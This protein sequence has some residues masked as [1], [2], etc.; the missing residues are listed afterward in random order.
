MNLYPKYA[1]LLLSVLFLMSII[2]CKKSATEPEDKKGGLPEG[3]ETLSIDING[4]SRD[5][6]LHT[7]TNWTVDEQLPLII[8]F[9]GDFGSA[10]ELEKVSGMSDI[11]DEQRFFVAYPAA[12]QVA[13]EVGIGSPVIEF[14]NQLITYVSNLYN[15]DQN[16]IYAAG[17]STGGEIVHDLVCELGDCLAGIA[18]VSGI[19]NQYCNETSNKV[20]IIVIHGTSDLV[21][22]YNGEEDINYYN[23]LYNCNDD[24][25]EIDISADLP[26]SGTVIQKT[27]SIC[28]DNLRVRLLRVVGGRHEWDCF[29][30]LKIWEFFNE[31]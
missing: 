4:Q 28:D 8:M 20:N 26:C 29:T 27:Y 21:V 15:I 31:L 5:F 14:T 10:P 1:I 11:A 12:V 24:L 3:S 9:H 16:R 2:S 6:L 17:F 25:T 22:P 18:S 7:P 30:S 13:F 23:Q 19:I